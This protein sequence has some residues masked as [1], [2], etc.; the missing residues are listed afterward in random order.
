[1]M[2]RGGALKTFGC[3]ASAKVGAGAKRIWASITV[4][5]HDKGHVSK[6]RDAGHTSLFLELHGLLDYGHGL[7]RALNI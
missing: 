6:R 7:V 3:R 1:M 2:C 4:E 5:K